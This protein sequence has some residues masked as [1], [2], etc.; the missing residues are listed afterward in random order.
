MAMLRKRNSE[1]EAE[2]A[3]LKAKMNGSDGNE[4]VLG[5]T[6][7]VASYYVLSSVYHLKHLHTTPTR[8]SYCILSSHQA[9]MVSPHEDWMEKTVTV[10]SLNVF[11]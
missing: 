1:L 7:G 4:G 11:V 8:S 2:L 10:P 6:V 9:K 3:A 5:I